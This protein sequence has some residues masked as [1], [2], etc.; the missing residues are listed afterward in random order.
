MTAFFDLATNMANCA[1][2]DEALVTSTVIDDI[3]RS[4][5]TCESKFYKTIEKLISVLD[6]L[7]Q[8]M[9]EALDAFFGADLDA[10]FNPALRDGLSHVTDSLQFPK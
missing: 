5:P 4:I 9:T 1:E 2:F 6:P 10:F 7:I 8:F 3:V